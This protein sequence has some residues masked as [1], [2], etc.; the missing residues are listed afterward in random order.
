MK[1]QLRDVKQKCLA[2]GM[3]GARRAGGGGVGHMNDDWTTKVSRM[4]GH[5]EWQ[6][7]D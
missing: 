3:I 7:A 2:G 6:V 4:A 5:S 1:S